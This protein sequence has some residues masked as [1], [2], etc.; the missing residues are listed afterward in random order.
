VSVAGDSAA[1]AGGLAPML[2]RHG[3]EVDFLVECDTGNARTG[4]QTPDEAAELAQ[5][6]ARLDGLRF[7]GLMTYPTLPESG[8][9]LRAAREAIERAGL[10][11]ERVSGGGTP[12]ARQTHEVDEVTELRPGTYVYGDRSCIANGSVAVADCALRVLATVVSVPTPTRAILDAGSKALTSDLAAGATGY[13]L[14]VEHPEAEVYKLNEE[15]GHVEVSG[16]EVGERI[17]VIPNHACV[18]VN[19][20][21]EI[22]MHRGGDVVETLRIA[23]RGKLR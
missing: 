2:A 18:T 16:C 4:V 17:T 5:L 20:Y 9:W 3:L 10:S 1:V 23:A 11:V 6:V 22:A 13:G 7:A 15:H 19:M 14:L 8:P 21:D 12:T